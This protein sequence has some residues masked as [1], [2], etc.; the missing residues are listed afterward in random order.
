MTSVKPDNVYCPAFYKKS[1]VSLPNDAQS[2]LKRGWPVIMV[3]DDDSDGDIKV[4]QA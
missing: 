4:F 3:I 2:N 1:V